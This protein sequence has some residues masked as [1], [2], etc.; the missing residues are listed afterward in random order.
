MCSLLEYFIFS[1]SDN[2]CLEMSLAG[3]WIS[4][5]L[6]LVRPLERISQWI[7][8]RPMCDVREDSQRM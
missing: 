6:W 3:A 5:L 8:I 1:S 4:A 2:L 7:N